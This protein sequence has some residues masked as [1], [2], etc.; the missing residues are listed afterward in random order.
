MCIFAHR[1]DEGGT[2]FQLHPQFR[3]HLRAYLDHRLNEDGKLRHTYASAWFARNGDWQLAV[4][5]AF[6]AGETLQALEWARR[7]A[8][9]E[10]AKGNLSLVLGWLGKSRKA[11]S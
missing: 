10:V 2:C 3:Q 8:I 6:P 1:L 4:Q 11:N 7:C 5:R 9:E